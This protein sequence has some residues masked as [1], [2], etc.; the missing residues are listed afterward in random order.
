[1]AWPTGASR[2]ATDSKVYRRLK[3]LPQAI[4]TV[5]ERTVVQTCVIHLLRNSFRYA[6]RR[7]WDEMSKDLDPD[8]HRL[9]RGRRQRPVR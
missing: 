1:V 5:W 8:L 2:S 7:Y 6:S 4:T 3:G 9:V